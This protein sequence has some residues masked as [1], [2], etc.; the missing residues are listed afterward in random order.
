ML[1]A[2]PYGILPCRVTVWIEVFVDGL[3]AIGLLNLCLCARLEV[4]VEVL[5]EVPA[6]G[7]VTVPQNLRTEGD[8]QR[9]TAE[10]VHV[11]LLQLVVGAHQ[12]RVKRNILWQPV[13]SEGLGQRHPL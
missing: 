6:Y 12:L 5:G 8:G 11:A 3:V 2:V 7:E 10:V 13:Q 9:R 1:D 4:Q